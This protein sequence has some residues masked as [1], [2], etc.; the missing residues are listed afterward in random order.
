VGRRSEGEAVMYEGWA[1]VAL[2]V[3]HGTVTWLE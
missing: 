2:Y 1:L 3:A